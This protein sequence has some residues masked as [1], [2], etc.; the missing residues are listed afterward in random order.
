[1]LKAAPVVA[2]VNSCGRN[3]DSSRKHSPL[4]HVTA[5]LERVA[6]F[7]APPVEGELAIPPLA[8]ASRAGL[9]WSLLENRRF[10]ISEDAE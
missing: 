5:P 3:N 6:G 2:A 10:P 4:P 8:L 7:I 9:A 1:M